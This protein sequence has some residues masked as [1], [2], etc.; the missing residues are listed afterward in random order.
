MI[1]FFTRLLV[2]LADNDH[3]V[4]QNSIILSYLCI[5]EGRQRQRCWEVSYT[6]LGVTVSVAL[7]CVN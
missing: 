1:F 4:L 6:Q 3:T 5:A 2:R 7:S